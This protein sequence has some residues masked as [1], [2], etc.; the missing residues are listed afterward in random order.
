MKVNPPS[1]DT[2]NHTACRLQFRQVVSLALAIPLRDW[3]MLWLLGSI[4]R[5]P[6]SFWN[7]ASQR[8]FGSKAFPVWAKVVPASVLHV[9]K[10]SFVAVM[11]WYETQT[12][13]VPSAAI[14]GL[15]SP[16]TDAPVG[17]RSHVLPPSLLVLT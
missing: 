9:T 17:L 11:L 12:L 7:D 14:Q 15:S 1:V 2:A 6:I 4:A 3:Y 16:G 8:W 5:F 13:P 10:M